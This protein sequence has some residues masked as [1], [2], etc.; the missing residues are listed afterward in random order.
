MVTLGAARAMT[1]GE[2]TLTGDTAG[3]RNWVEHTERGG[4]SP[5]WDAATTRQ[6]MLTGRG[7]KE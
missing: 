6:V 4:S 2:G 1:V 5:P 7:G 3:S